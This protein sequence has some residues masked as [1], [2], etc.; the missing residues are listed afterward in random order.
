MG[1]EHDRD[2]VAFRVGVADPRLEVL[3]INVTFEEDVLLHNSTGFYP[4]DSRHGRENPA[5][6][7]PG[8]SE[9]VILTFPNRTLEE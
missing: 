7:Q 9:R 8:R 3:R 1:D 4:P 2:A 5:P 6:P